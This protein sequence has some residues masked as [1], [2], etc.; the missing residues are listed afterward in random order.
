MILIIYGIVFVVLIRSNFMVKNFIACLLISLSIVLY[1]AKSLSEETEEAI[2]PS[3]FFKTDTKSTKED[4]GLGLYM[5]KTEQ[6][7]RERRYLI[8]EELHDCPSDQSPFSNNWET[9]LP[10]DPNDPYSPIR[11]IKHVCAG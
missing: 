4:C 8:I 6:G 3:G 11:L 9:R 1:P 5:V 2:D 7:C 10:E